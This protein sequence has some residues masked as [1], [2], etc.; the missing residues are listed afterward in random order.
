MDRKHNIN[1]INLKIVNVDFWG[2]H[3]GNKGGMRIFYNSDYG[4]GDI[5]IFKSSGNNEHDSKSPR[6]EFILNADSDGMDT[7]EDK[8]FTR[9]LLSLLADYLKIE[10]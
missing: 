9:K 10:D 5:E 1:E 2:E 8:D 6:E 7:Q 3:R 4:W